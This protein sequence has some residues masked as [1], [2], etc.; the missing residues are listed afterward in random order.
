MK[1]KVL[2]TLVAFIAILAQAV[3]GPVSKEQA[4]EFAVNFLQEQGVALQGDLS[5]IEG[6]VRAADKRDAAP[7]YYVFNNGQ[8][9]GFVIISGDNRTQMVLGFSTTGHFYN[10]EENPA[11]MFLKQYESEMDILDRMNVTAPLDESVA[12]RSFLQTPAREAIQPLIT[13]EWSQ[14]VPYNASC[15]MYSTKRTLTGCVTVAMA[16][17]LYYYR[18]RMASTLQKDIPGYTTKTLKIKVNGISKGTKIDWANMYDRYD[19]T[20]TSA[21][22]TAVANLLFYC[23]AVLQADFHTSATSAK[24]AN[25]PPRLADTFG[26]NSPSKSERENFTYAQWKEMIINNLQQK[27]P[28]LYRAVED[29]STLGH[30]FLID[31]FDGGDLF[32]VNWGWGGYSNGFYSLSV[33]NPYDVEGEDAFIKPTSSG[34]NYIKDQAAYFNLQ[35][36]NGYSDKD[37][38]TALTCLINS[39]SG[40][41]VTATYSNKTSN[42]AN[43]LFGLGYLDSK[44]QLQVLKTYSTTSTSLAAN[45]A[46]SALKYTLA[47]SDFT[48]CKL[49]KGTYNLFPVSKVAGGEWEICEQSTTPKFIKAVYSSSLT[50]SLQTSGTDLVVTDIAFPGDC[51]RGNAKQPVDVTIVNNGEDF[52][53]SLYLFASASSSK[54]TYQS[55]AKPFIPAGKKVTLRLYFSSSSVKT[56]NIWITTDN[57]GSKVLGQSKVT[58]SSTVYARQLTATGWTLKNESSSKNVVGNT[59]QGTVK[60]TNTSACKYADYLRI[61]LMKKETSWASTANRIYT[62]LELKPGESKTLE[63]RYDGLDPSNKY[64]VCI[65]HDDM[66]QIYKGSLYSNIY[67]SSAPMWYDEQDNIAPIT[68]ASTITVPAAAVAVDFTGTTGTVKKVV[69][70]SNPNTIYLVG[71]SE[72]IISGLSGKNFVKGNTADAITLNS[73]YSFFTPRWFTA[74][75]ITFKMVPTLGTTGKAGWQTLVVPFDAKNVTCEGYTLDWFKSDNDYGKNFWLKEF[76]AIEGQ[77]TVLFGYAQEINAN[78]PYL[79][80]VPGTKW[81]EANNLVG[82]T[83]EFTGTNVI[84]YNDPMI[85]SASP[86]FNFRGTFTNQSVQ[87]SYQLDKTGAKFSYIAGASTIKPFTCYFV[88]TED[89]IT[90]VNALNIGTFVSEA[91][92][93]DMMETEKT[94]VVEVYNVNGM[95][96]GTAE[97]YGDKVSLEGFEKGIYIIRGKKFVVK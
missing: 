67:V 85:V 7:C 69:P 16:Q 79:Y 10:N 35:P 6:P 89:D 43:F 66:A 32:H 61:Y 15:P 53:G 27:R 42:K 72:S 76:S 8:N 59:I 22:K 12:G 26:F 55:T 50:L 2:A 41:N 45:A 30:S 40:T 14:G 60:V 48:A 23:A 11:L 24:T 9:G 33:M 65:F 62:Y 58:I 82:K 96:V 68:P 97:V 25:I 90:D 44:E 93:I 1:K 18:G 95:K 29:A 81:G 28:V 94:G 84:V 54:G 83:M 71:A 92:G 74:K 37:P 75:K 19:G 64:A 87:K 3:A 77:N 51:C 49:A 80:A 36:L 52:F 17:L 34:Q 57:A 13:C 56:Y 38:R 46:T 73:K 31:G 4:K 91:D 21:Q 20:Q 47:A 88:K 39:V 78:Q 63:F 70:N 86:A 5:V